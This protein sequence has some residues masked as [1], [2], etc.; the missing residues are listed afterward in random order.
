MKNV[1]IA[2]DIGASGGRHLAKYYQN[3]KQITEEVYRFKNV[4]EGL[5][6]YGLIWNHNRI[7]THVL[8]G[9][10]IAFKTYDAIVSVGIDTW[11]VDYVLLDENQQV[12]E[13]V[14][15][16]RNQRTLTVI[17]DVH[18]KISFKELYNITGCQ[19]QSF[20]SIYQMYHDKKTGKLDK[21][22]QF[23]MMPEYL[24]YKL[25]GQMLHEYTNATTTGL[26]D[27]NTSNYSDKILSRLGFPARLFT[28]PV[29][30]GLYHPLSDD[31][32]SLL[33][34]KTRVCLVATH[35][36]ASAVE[37][38]DI[39]MNE[40]YLSSGT[41]SLL[42]IK[43]DRPIISDAARKHNFSHEGGIGYIRFQKNIMGLWMAQFLKAE[44]N[45][46]DY[47]Q[48]ADEASASDYDEIVDVN[49]ESFL[50]P[51]SMVDAIKS[52]LVKYNKAL[53]K[54]RGD[55]A[56]LVYHSLAQSY[57]EALDELEEITQMRID[58]LTIFGG[59]AKNKHFNH[60]IKQHVT[61]KLNIY[62]IEATAIG[63][64]NVQEKFDE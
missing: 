36:T 39:P 58:T 29:K 52:Y 6:E 42:G 30:T 47:Y 17:D 13:P 63:N 21:A 43:V 26:I 48:M 54:T 3:G 33:G 22:S 62:P 44:L 53:P 57:E 25:T 51:L 1:R 41:W 24:Y 12:I 9:L 61:R 56:N 7:F 34:G 4:I 8:E 15:A 37:G 35:D 28:Q 27:L 2:I 40:A 50:A 64:L 45:F 59:G 55:F 60:V 10:K 18:E 46:D 11:G 16:Y 49:H 14:F 19:F 32:S 38:V 5:P 20:T 23:L 31:I